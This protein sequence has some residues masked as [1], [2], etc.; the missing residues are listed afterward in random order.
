MKTTEILWEPDPEFSRSSRMWKFCEYLTNEYDL[1]PCS[2]LA[3][4][5]WSV[6]RPDLYWSELWNQADFVYEGEFKESMTSDKFFETKWFEGVKFNYA[7]N[8]FRNN[9]PDSPAI[10][11]I[12]E[13]EHEKIIT[14]HELRELVQRTAN[15]FKSFGLTKGDRVAAIMPNC[16]DTIICALATASIGAVWASASPDQGES[17]CMDR[18]GQ[19]EPKLLISVN[20]YDYNGKNFD[21]HQKITSIV[22]QLPTL[23]AHFNFNADGKIDDRL[24]SDLSINAKYKDWDLPNEFSYQRV[25]FDHPLYILF[26]SGTTGKP[27]CIVHG[28]GGVLL[29]HTNEMFMH[30]DIRRDD[31][32]FFFTTCGWM[33]WNWMVSALGCGACVM[34][35]DG[36]PAFTSTHHLWKLADKLG[37]TQLGMGAKYVSI[38]SSYSPKDKLDFSAL[39]TIFTTGSPLTADLFDWINKNIS[40]KVQICS[41]SGGTDIVGCFVGGNPVLPVHIG[42]IQGALLGMDVV[43][44][45]HNQQPV[46]GGKGELV[47]QKSFPN[48]P[49]F[50]WNDP[51]GEKYKNSYFSENSGVWTHGDLISINPENG[52]VIIYGRSDS[53]LNPGGIRI[54]PAEI[55]AQ[56]ESLDEIEDSIVIG[57]PHNGDEKILLFVVLK[58]GLE[59]NSEL[60]SHVQTT[61]RKN[62][63]PRHVP[64]HIYAV[65]DIPKTYNGKKME[66]AVKN[67]FTGRP[68]DNLSAMANPES[69]KQFEQI[70]ETL[71]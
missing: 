53:T 21:I 35:Y 30:S 49:V 62:A 66:K 52:G 40:K 54:G 5:S 38:S 60:K 3:V 14:F 10:H 13:N 39:R 27:K 45:D 50:F 29:A 59:M 26:S 32:L 70:R 67:I 24:A 25:S 23:K 37:V 18:F 16:S 61:L 4:H 51:N 15:K 20:Q 64:K 6:D 2:Y 42:E 44:Y 1:S 19:I 56:V 69:L 33:M 12:W 58:K 9:L 41:I 22:Q 7:E 31:K 34:T 55:Y 57:Y 63:T 68:V 47:C 11:E 43:A 46:Y 48:T 71:L 8:M 17:G 36:S 65:S 28:H